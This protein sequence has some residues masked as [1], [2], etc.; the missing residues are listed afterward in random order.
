MHKVHCRWDPA[1]RIYGAASDE[2]FRNDSAAGATVVRDQ[3]RWHV[4]RDCHRGMDNANRRGTP[5]IDG[6]TLDLLLPEPAQTAVVS[7]VRAKMIGP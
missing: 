6:P 7:N 1:P 3:R 5:A 4:S 2:M